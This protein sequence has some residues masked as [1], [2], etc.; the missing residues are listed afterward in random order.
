MCF[1]FLMC[2]HTEVAYCMTDLRQHYIPRGTALH[3][4]DVDHV[5]FVICG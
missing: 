2:I 4:L 1:A 3:I 5:N